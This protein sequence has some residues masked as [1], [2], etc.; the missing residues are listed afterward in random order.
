MSLLGEGKYL[1]LNSLPST[2]CLRRSEFLSLLQSEWTTRVLCRSSACYLETERKVL[3]LRNMP[4]SA[5]L[6]SSY[7]VTSE[8][9]TTF[10][11]FTRF[12]LALSTGPFYLTFMNAIRNVFK[13]FIIT[14]TVLWVWPLEGKMKPLIKGFVYNWTMEETSVNEHSLLSQEASTWEKDF[15]LWLCNDKKVEH[16][17]LAKY[18]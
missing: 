10:L 18:I 8:S 15:L 6:L 16:F 5:H 14:S 4:S 11:I 13:Q 3:L 2:L 7:H 9:A 12:T 17:V 1:F